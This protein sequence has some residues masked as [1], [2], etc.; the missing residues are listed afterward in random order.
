MCVHACVCVLGCVHVCVQVCAGVRTDVCRYVQV[1]FP[2]TT[3]C[4]RMRACVCT[5]TC[6]N[7]TYQF[8]HP[9]VPLYICLICGYTALMSPKR[10]E[11]P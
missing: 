8:E 9:C 7:C 1:F 4:V 10:M 2:A 3:V 5:C 11:Q 6:N